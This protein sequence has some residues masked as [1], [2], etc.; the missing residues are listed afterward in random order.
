M[1]LGGPSCQC[2]VMSV[3]RPAATQGRRTGL[4]LQHIGAGQQG[5]Q[6]QVDLADQALDRGLVVQQRLEVVGA[7]VVLLQEDLGGV[8]VAGLGALELAVPDADG[9]L[10]RLLGVQLDLLAHGVWRCGL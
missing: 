7:D 10:C 1:S 8:Q 5:Q 4:T 9:R 2:L 3:C 6:H